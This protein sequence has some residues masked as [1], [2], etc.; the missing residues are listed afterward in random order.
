MVGPKGTVAPGYPKVYRFTAEARA[1]GSNAPDW[2]SLPAYAKR[3]VV[4]LCE[5]ATIP[6]NLRGEWPNFVIHLPLVF[7]SRF[8]AIQAKV[9]A[10]YS[11]A[12]PFS[13]F[14]SAGSS[15]LK[16]GDY[17][18]YESY[19]SSTLSLDQE[20]KDVLVGSCIYL[21]DPGG[22]AAVRSLAV[23]VG[24]RELPQAEEIDP[25]PLT[26]TYLLVPSTLPALPVGHAISVEGVD[27]STG[28]AVS[29]L[30]TVKSMAPHAT[31]N[32]W[33][34]EFAESL[35]GA[36]RASAVFRGNLVFATEGQS[37]VQVLG[38]GD[39][40][41]AWP[42]YQL[43]AGPLTYVSSATNP[44]GIASTLAVSVDGVEWMEVSDFYRARPD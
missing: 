8:S 19:R 25:T 9:K 23:L 16:S 30:L 40:R 36:V 33:N 32:A 17:F 4:G 24:S 29:A 11:Y 41:K 10:D 28:T 20:Y 43:S 31:Q 3:E 6:P 44:R 14:Y 37:R 12:L 21:D 13:F 2:R 38:H 7:D 35:P 18:F 42:E 22:T 34:V 39:A 15:I 1:F 5:N 26:G 27:S